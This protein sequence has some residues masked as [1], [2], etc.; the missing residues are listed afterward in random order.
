MCLTLYF[1]NNNY[2]KQVQCMTMRTQHIEFIYN[3]KWQTIQSILNNKSG[4]WEG[5]TIC[6]FVSRSIKVKYSSVLTKSLISHISHSTFSAK[7]KLLASYMI[8][9]IYNYD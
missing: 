7:L 1:V 4:T 5:S 9:H 3:L 8:T 6:I 2:L